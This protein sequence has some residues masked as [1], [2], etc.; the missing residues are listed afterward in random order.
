MPDF[1]MIASGISSKHGTTHNPWNLA[2]NAGGSSSGAGA[3]LAAGFGALAVG[4][5]IGGSIRIPSAFCGTFGFKPTYGRVPYHDPA[6]WLVAGPMARTV[7]D[8]ALMMNVIARPDERDYSALPYDGRD[9]L[10]QLDRSVAGLRIGLLDNIGFGL[11]VE[12]QVR[13][14]LLDAGRRFEAMGAI[15]DPIAPI[16]DQ[17][18]EPHFDRC[19]HVW[20]YVRFTH[21][22]G[23]QRQ[24]VLP[25]IAD[26][27]RKTN[28][29]N[30]LELMKSLLEV[31]SIRQRT[32]SPFVRYDYVLTPTMA[33]LPYGAELPWPP[34]GTAHNPFCFPFNISEQP[35][36]SINGGFSRDGLPIG[37]QIV[38]R[39]F[40]DHGVL[41]VARAYE[42]ATGFYDRH[43]NLC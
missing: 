2:R 30:V 20:S 13:D 38:G 29:A 36:A 25:V 31:Q 4:S 41:Q 14:M 40:D 42:Q 33:V 6:S 1:G 39:R 27:C 37:L 43:P 21:L 18:P 12:P 9:Y 26:W 5:D 8:A 32:L 7:A 17:D 28:S 3:G 16:F 10:D 22:T 11:P 24:L 15:V 35:A 23:M 19:V 34:G